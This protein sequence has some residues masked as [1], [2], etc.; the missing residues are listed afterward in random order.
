MAHAAARPGADRR[1]LSS[2]VMAAG[3]SGWN[4]KHDREKPPRRGVPPAS[5]AGSGAPAT[6]VPRPVTVSE[7]PTRVDGVSNTVH[8]WAPFI[9]RMTDVRTRLSAVREPS[10][11]PGSPRELDGS[12]VEGPQAWWSAGAERD[13]AAGGAGGERSP[14]GGGRRWASVGSFFCRRIRQP[15]SEWHRIVASVVELLVPRHAAAPPAR[16]PAFLKS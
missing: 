2:P 9:R 14:A 16:T 1:A 3:S 8:P 4:E 12:M 15:G 13:A 5:H 7:T 10:S 11:S 6:T